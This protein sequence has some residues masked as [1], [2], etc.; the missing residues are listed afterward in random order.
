MND[1]IREQVLDTLGR[2][3]LASLISF[4]AGNVKAPV[5]LGFLA[6]E[7][8]TDEAMVKRILCRLENEDKIHIISWSPFRFLLRPKGDLPVPRPEHDPD[9]Y[10]RFLEVEGRRQAAGRFIGQF[11]EKHA[12][13]PNLK[14][15]GEHLGSDNLNWVNAQLDILIDRG[16]IIRGPAGPVL[17]DTGRKFYNL[18]KEGTKTMQTQQTAPAAPAPNS[19][20]A[21]VVV[22]TSPT[23]KRRRQII[24][25]DEESRIMGTFLYDYFVIQ[26]RKNSPMVHDLAEMIGWNESRVSKVLRS[27]LAAGWIT[28]GG[29]ARITW[30]KFTDAAKERF[31]PKKEVASSPAPKPE[32]EKEKVT[33]V[34]SPRFQAPVPVRSPEPTRPD[35]STVD[36]ADLVLELIDRGYV[37]KRG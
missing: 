31:G 10:T 27:F 22:R 4:A 3:V 36:T 28:H 13:G 19:P 21:T 17:T 18:P 25:A 33:I 16:I 8:N 30:F 7:A 12:R 26:N 6:R 15:V 5:Q 29:G 11:F 2:K 14:E 37:V 35:L 1:T 9:R 24:S 23:G 20:K 32:P 34:P